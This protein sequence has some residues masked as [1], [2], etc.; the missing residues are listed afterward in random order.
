MSDPVSPV[1]V[2]VHGFLG[3]VSIGP[4]NYFRGVEAALRADGLAPLV[5]ALPYGGSIAERA[6][7]LAAALKDHGGGPFVLIGHSMGGLDGRYLIT[8]LDPDHR[9]KA[10]V[11]V[12]TPHLGAPAA[13]R[14]LAGRGHLA[15]AARTLCRPALTDLD[16][17]TRLRD[18]I[19][20]RP[21]VDYVSY[22]ARRPSAEIPRLIRW[23]AGPAEGENDGVV[24][25]DSA[26][27]GTFR[28]FVR[29]DHVE[30]L[31]WN[32]GANDPASQRPIDHIPFWRQAVADAIRLV[33]GVRYDTGAARTRPT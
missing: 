7:V 20:D 24:A 3:F 4:I 8:N 33:G 19:P 21:D 9:V 22:A 6:N 13:A 11:T 15:L 17:R 1:P 23:A 28:G 25:V 30:V 12:A 31:G 16:P 2:L 5:P 32:L 26:R 18:A 10:L 27:W 14:L 29:A